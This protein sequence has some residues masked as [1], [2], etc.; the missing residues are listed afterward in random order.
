MVCYE[1][2]LIIDPGS[3]YITQEECACQFDPNVVQFRGL[4]PVRNPGLREK[5]AILI[6]GS[7]RKWSSSSNGFAPY[8]ME[9]SPKK[10]LRPAGGHLRALIRSLLSGPQAPDPHKIV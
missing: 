9:P 10:F 4:S 6:A 5:L 3:Q 2:G 8:G 1:F 7:F